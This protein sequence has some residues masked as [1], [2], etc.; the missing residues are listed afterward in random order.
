MENVGIVQYQSGQRNFIKPVLVFQAMSYIQQTER[1]QQQ[2]LEQHEQ[3][4]RDMVKYVEGEQQ[5]MNQMMFY[6][7][8][9][10]KNCNETIGQLR[11]IKWEHFLWVFGSSEIVMCFP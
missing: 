1:Q 7:K 6:V 2:Q 10:A 11:K 4:Y 3:R 8:D 9:V 5:R